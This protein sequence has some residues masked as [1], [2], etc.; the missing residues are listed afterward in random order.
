MLSTMLSISGYFVTGI[1]AKQ[2]MP[3]W[4]TRSEL[5]TLPALKRLVSLCYLNVKAEVIFTAEITG[6]SPGNVN[7]FANV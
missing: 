2:W 7:E 3:S 4:S 6:D 1:I 5:R